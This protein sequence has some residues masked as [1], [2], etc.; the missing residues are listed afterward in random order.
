MSAQARH[1]LGEIAQSREDLIVTFNHHASVEKM[2]EQTKK[3][4]F[5]LKSTAT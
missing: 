1:M 4:L 3:K 5:D 2:R